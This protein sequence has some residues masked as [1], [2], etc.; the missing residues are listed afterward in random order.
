MTKSSV[1]TP[2]KKEAPASGK[3]EPVSKKEAIQQALSTLGRNA[4]TKDVQG[5]LEQ[6]YGQ[7]ASKYYISEQ[8]MK[9]KKKSKKPQ[10]AAPKPVKAMTPQ[11]AETRS[12]DGETS[13][14]SEPRGQAAVVAEAVVAMSTMARKVGWDEVQNLLSVIRGK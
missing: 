7:K 1:A 4:S 5:F 9:L 12:T 6:K 3:T 13:N 14:R 10:P 11:R 8:R 2:Q